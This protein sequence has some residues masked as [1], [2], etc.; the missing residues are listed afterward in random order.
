MLL[1]GIQLELVT[2][3]ISENMSVRR[4]QSR[5]VTWSV[6]IIILV[7][8]SKSQSKTLKSL[9]NLDTVIMTNTC[10]YSIQL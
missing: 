10:S 5:F 4:E 3:V 7:S 6:L 1:I 9:V 8:A 2:V